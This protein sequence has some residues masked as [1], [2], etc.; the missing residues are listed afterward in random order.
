MRNCFAALLLL[1]ALVPIGRPGTASPGD[2][3]PPVTDARWTHARTNDEGN[4]F[5]PYSD[6]AA[7]MRRRQALRE[8][9]LAACGLWPLPERGSLKPQVYGRLDRDGYTIEKVVIE[10]QPGFYL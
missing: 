10:T 8:Q 9:V 2:K 6:R 3:E 7:W 1:I 5:Q 4:N